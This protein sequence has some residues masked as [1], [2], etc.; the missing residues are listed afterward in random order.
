MVL[1]VAELCSGAVR[2]TRMAVGIRAS[3]KRFC[4]LL[5]ELMTVEQRSW[6]C[7]TNW[8][9]NQASR[10]PMGIYQEQLPQFYPKMGQLTFYRLNG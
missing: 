3:V 10:L 4:Q 6:R 1:D 7:E 9:N 8:R 2:S 5:S